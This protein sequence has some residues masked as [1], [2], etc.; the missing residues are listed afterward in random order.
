MG[1]KDPGAPAIEPVELPNPIATGASEGQSL[2]PNAV[3]LV[4]DTAVILEVRLGETSLSIRQLLDLRDGSVI[5]LDRAVDEPVD[6]L[7]NGKVIARGLLVAHGDQFGV[8]IT[9]IRSQV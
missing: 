2:T 4:Q 7:L 5:E 9:E 8:Q 1:A 6:V 3:E